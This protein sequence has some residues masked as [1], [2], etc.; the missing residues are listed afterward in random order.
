MND[1]LNTLILFLLFLRSLLAKFLGLQID[2]IVAVKAALFSPVNATILAL[3]IP[4]LNTGPVA[5]S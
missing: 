3:S 2:H 5:Q 1:T 4:S